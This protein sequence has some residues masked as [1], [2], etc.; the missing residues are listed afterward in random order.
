MNSR[1]KYLKFI[2]PGRK[3]LKIWI[4]SSGRGTLWWKY[5]RKLKR[6]YATNC[7]FRIFR[8][9]WRAK[10]ANILTSVLSDSKLLNCLVIIMDGVFQL[11]IIYYHP[12]PIPIEDCIS[13]TL[14]LI[15]FGM[16]MFGL[17]SSIL[18]T[19]VFWRILLSRSTRVNLAIG[20]ANPRCPY[21]ETFSRLERSQ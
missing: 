20:T 4:V 17:D 21:T 18:G 3:V 9:W 2:I 7:N 13:L 5:R 1:E 8:S 19:E 15:F 11:E 6:L 12:L 16:F 14:L 10:E